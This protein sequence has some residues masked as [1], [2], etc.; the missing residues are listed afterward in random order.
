MKPW[1]PLPLLIGIATLAG[2]I[3]LFLFGGPV[4]GALL[5]AGLLAY[6]LDPLV[7]QLQA[8]LKLGRPL[9]ATTVYLLAVLLPSALVMALG[10]ALWERLPG[11]SLELS[12]ALAEMEGWLER[13]LMLFGFQL[14]PQVLV[15]SLK[16][17]ATN[18]LTTLSISSGGILATVTENLLWSLVVLVSLYYFLKDGP[19]IKPWLVGLLPADYQAEGRRLLDETD[20]IWGVFLRMQL[21]IF[22]ILAVLFL[23]STLLIVWLFRNGWLPLSPVGLAILFILVYTAIQQ[24][25]NL[26]LRPQLL[27]RTLKL[28][29][30][31]VFVSLIA[32]LALSGVLAAIIVVP[33]LATLK[34][35]GRYV[36]AKLLDRPP[37]PEPALPEAI[38]LTSEGSEIEVPAEGIPSSIKKR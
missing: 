31:V 34:L 7:Q 38:A 1:S 23:S 29:P 3:A 30:G 18:G 27:G 37:W 13:P 17:S 2:L 20:V 4:L 16:R 28:H 35:A 26:W 8:R 21:L 9:A 32:A 36:H 19:H 25:D 14:Q 33:A 6:L 24:V 22:F 15:E 11:L 10:A 5:I 12:E